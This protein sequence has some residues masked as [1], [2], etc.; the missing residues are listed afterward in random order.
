MVILYVFVIG[1][2][3][4]PKIYSLKFFLEKVF[5]ILPDLL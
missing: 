5:N 2:I 3:P 1:A 4:N